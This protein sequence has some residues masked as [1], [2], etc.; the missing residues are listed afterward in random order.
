M[1]RKYYSKKSTKKY[2][3][4]KTK[5][6]KFNLYSHKSAKSQ[7]KQ[8]YDLSKKVNTVYKLT[9]PDIDT[10]TWQINPSATINFGTTSVVNYA[11]AMLTL[12][13]AT[14][15]STIGSNIDH[16]FVRSLKFNFLYRYN[17]LSGTSQSIY[18]RLTFLKLRT[19]ASAFPSINGIYSSISDPYVR[20][21]GPL[22][23]GLYDSGYKIVG[24]YKLKITN[25]KPNLDF[26]CKFKN[27]RLDTG[28]STQPKN[29]IMCYVYI[30]NPNYSNQVNHSEGQAFA[31]VAWSTPSKTPLNQ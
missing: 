15:L 20:V 22:R 8:I 30:W 12:L 14:L 29:G 17:S 19:S 4:K 18:I 27:I 31:K 11:Q 26:S 5:F 25:E 28:A 10:L 3:R 2:G 6:T 1:P 9:K 13:D 16:I 21:K 7:A 23:D 24:D